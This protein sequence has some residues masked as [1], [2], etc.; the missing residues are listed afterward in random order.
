[1]NQTE[2]DGAIS[3]VELKR[4]WRV[5]TWAGFLGSTYFL[6]CVSGAPRIKYLTELEATPLDFGVI[7]SLSTLVLAFQILGSILCNRVA[8]R[9]RLWMTVAVIHRLSFLGVIAA[10]WLPVEVRTRI[11]WIMV[12]L[13]CHDALAQTGTPIWFSWMADLVPKESMSRHWAVRQRFITAVT[14]LVMISIALGFHYFE[15]TDRVILGFTVLALI[16]VV[17]GVTDILLFR[18][19]PEPPN[20]RVGSGPWRD[21]LLQPLRDRSF[22]PVL[23]FMGFW[24]FATFAADPFMGLYMIQSLHLN[25]LTV[26]L[27]GTAAA[28]GIVLS[29]HFWG[30]VCDGFGFRPALQALVLAKAFTPVAL[31]LIPNHPAA[32][33][34]LL[35]GVWFVDGVLNGGI[36]LAMQGPLLKSTP[37]R[38]RTMYIAAT[39]FFAIGVMAS[40]AP[41][42]FGYVIKNVT[43]PASFGL[44]WIHPSGYHVAFAASAVLRVGAFVFAARI[45][46]PNAPAFLPFVRRLASFEYFRV[47]RLIRKIHEPSDD[48]TRLEAA[49][50]LGETRSPMAIG[51]LIHA[52]RDS[53]RDVRDAA[54]DALGQ[55]GAAEAAE[56]LGRAL[57][58]PN[59][60]IASPAAR[61]LGQI[62]GQNALR[63]LM[64]NLRNRD[65]EAL[66]DTVD[67]LAQIGDDAAVLPLMCLF[68]EAQDETLR[69]RIAAALA[70][71]SQV[72][73]V[74]NVL[75][76][77]LVR[78]PTD[79][80]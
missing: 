59:L 66:G 64:L 14:I 67:S 19:V 48:A 53:N 70:R 16:G 35:A 1:M 22:R 47:S 11:A 75:E 79:P 71:L 17:L 5:I 65:S 6:L 63:A 13:F 7:S 30:L 54:A 43:I 12:V 4:A 68:F 37:R 3:A 18:R 50:Q 39:N 73:T 61:A 44:G 28:L 58:D 9:R 32:A 33:V 45:V 2:A 56:Y 51:E 38:N 57:F 34:P 80:P 26:Q 72:D 29:S 40:A 27:L 36:G 62:S 76:V 21:T 23:L 46:E 49:R 20:E 10:P 69:R 55:I 15:Q 8:R 42:L 77:L 52:L 25:V 74:E 78:Q 41:V 31:I 24:S 60:G